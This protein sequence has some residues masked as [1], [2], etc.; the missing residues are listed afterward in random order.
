MTLMKRF[1]PLILI[2]AGL[3]WLIV[4]WRGQSASGSQGH[5]DVFCAAGLQKP[6]TAAA[7]AFEKETGIRVST[8]FGGTGTL[9]SQLQISK[10]GDL[11]IAADDGSLAEAAKRE[12]VAE[13]LPVAIQT[14]VIA[15]P[16][17]NPK[18]IKTLDDLLKADVKFGVANPEAASISKITRKVLG[19]RW[20]AF[21]A[22]AAVM[23]PTVTELAADV[24]IGSVDA[25]IVWDSTARMFP[26]LEIVSVAPLSEHRE[27]ASAAVLTACKQ[28]SVALKFA[29]F[30]AAPER[31]GKTMEEFGFVPAGGDAWALTP[32]VVLFSGGV[33]RPAIEKLIQE[34]A[35][36][37]GVSISTMFNGCGILCATMKTMGSTENPKFPDMYYAC[38]VCF[39]P[40]VAENFPEAVML[41]ETEIGIAM[42]KGNPKNIQTLADL[43]RPG[44]R[45]G[46]CNAEQSTLGY[47]T[48]AVLKSMNLL[49]SVEKNASSQV[50]TADLLV[51]QMRVGSL[52]A[53]VVYR[54]SIQ[55]QEEHFDFIPLPGDKA[56]AVQPFAVRK[57]SSYRQISQRFLTFLRKNH[58]KFTDVG[59]AWKGDTEAVKSSEIVLPDWLKPKS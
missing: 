53:A 6:V 56:R 15:V 21:A 57:D 58:D 55:H 31:G 38:D 37:E 49:E 39:V 12:L 5:L 2:A 14:P 23:K 26:E 35:D 16:K 24:K 32:E 25:A 8:Q 41:T 20:D 17:G 36:H 51:N 10:T 22:K 3:A 30:L 4:Q 29:R 40:P 44:L 43:A 18:G 45:I 59:F 52:D 50:P 28:A 1:L 54:V 9:L 11:F 7:A 33:N 13:V 34:F 47:M 19:D 48:H 27:P 42:P 46:L